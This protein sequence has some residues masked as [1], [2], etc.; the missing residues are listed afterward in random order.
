MSEF[1]YFN[2]ELTV[3]IDHF[4]VDLRESSRSCKKERDKSVELHPEAKGWYSLVFS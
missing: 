3:A 4:I 1:L 2:R